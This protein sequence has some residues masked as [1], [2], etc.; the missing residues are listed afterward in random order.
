MRSTKEDE[1]LEILAGIGEVGPETA[2]ALGDKPGYAAV[3]L[4]VPA[5]AEFAAGT[6]WVLWEGSGSVV[7]ESKRKVEES[8]CTTDDMAAALSGLGD[9]MGME[10]VSADDKG[11]SAVAERRAPET[12]EAG[13]AT[14]AAAPAPADA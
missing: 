3:E 14:A 4:K 10:A 13:A 7:G 1:L 11:R 9:H 8:A 2:A 6:T 12:S 5:K